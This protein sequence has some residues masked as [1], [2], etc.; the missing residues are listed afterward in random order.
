MINITEDEDG[1]D[2]EFTLR[3]LTV[4]RFVSFAEAEAFA[5]DI[6][7]RFTGLTATAFDSPRKSADGGDVIHCVC[8]S[9]EVTDVA[10]CEAAIRQLVHDRNQSRRARRANGGR[11]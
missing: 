4:G 2:V 6:E 11:L 9:G 7:R 5:E 3:Q 10:R 8:V 1:F